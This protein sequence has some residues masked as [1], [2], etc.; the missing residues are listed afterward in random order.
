[1]QKFGFLKFFGLKKYFCFSCLVEE[2][3]F[4][5]R[6]RKLNWNNFSFYLK[7]VLMNYLSCSN[8]NLK[9]PKKSLHNFYAT[10]TIGFSN[11]IQ[12]KTTSSSNEKLT[13]SKAANH[14]HVYVHLISGSDC[15]CRLHV[16]L[17]FTS[18]ERN[19]A[20]WKALTS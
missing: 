2:N 1:M 15:R 12:L 19:A 10:I 11:L 5:L 8:P 18:K 13:I 9:I 20:M 14:Q 6:M 16:P 4:F 3:D 7:K 17:F